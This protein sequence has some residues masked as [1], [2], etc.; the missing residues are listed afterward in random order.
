MVKNK[1]LVCKVKPNISLKSRLSVQ[2][3]LTCSSRKAL[4]SEFKK[5]KMSKEQR[6]DLLIKTMGI[7]AIS[8]SEGYPKIG[9]RYNAIIGMY[10]SGVWKRS[11]SSWKQGES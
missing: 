9:D 3:I 7:S 8:Y 1:N 5:H 11:Y 4:E 6:M 2:S 10:L